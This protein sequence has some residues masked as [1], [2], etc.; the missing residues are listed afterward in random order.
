MPVNGRLEIRHQVNR[1]KIAEAQLKVG[2]RYQAS[3]TD[4]C[5][6]TRWWAFGSLEEFEGVK[7]RQWAKEKE[8]GI[9]EEGEG[10]QGEG[11]EGEGEKRN[12]VNDERRILIGEIPDSLALVVENEAVEMR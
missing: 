5:L 6:G 4:I 1:V 11:E 7:F 9:E 10:E 8:Q 12:K 3:I 2:E